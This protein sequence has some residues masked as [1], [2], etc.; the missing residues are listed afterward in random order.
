MGGAGEGGPAAAAMRL[1]AICPGQVRRFFP[2][3][4]LELRFV[5]LAASSPGFSSI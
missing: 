2:V 5:L 3:A 4:G 1:G